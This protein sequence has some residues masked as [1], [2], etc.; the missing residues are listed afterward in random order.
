MNILTCLWIKGDL[1]DLQKHCL[2][3]WLRLNY[4]VNLHSY[5]PDSI[6][7]NHENLTIIKEDLNLRTMH[8]NGNLPESDYWRFKHL[9][10]NGGTWIDFDMFLLKRLPDKDLIISSEHAK[11]I[12]AFK[13]K[14]DRTPNIGI[15]RFPKGDKILKKTIDKIEKMNKENL[16]CNSF[17]KVFQKLVEKNEPYN[18]N[19]ADPNDYC[20][21]SWAY[22]KDIYKET[23]L[24]GEKY[25]IKQ[26]PLNE[27]FDQ[28]YSIHLWH[29]IKR[30]K[31]YEP[32]ENSVYD[33]I[34]QKQICIDD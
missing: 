14:V 18:K 13:R 10:E 26:K 1:P 8:S 9:Y 15:M 23:S 22:A 34:I 6:N 31:N 4:K 7:F 12:G 16:S 21:I 19:I 5:D 20:P 33:Q 2:K 11:Q 29:N 28:A 25:G 27:I 30:T 24:T 3:S 32:I 17:M